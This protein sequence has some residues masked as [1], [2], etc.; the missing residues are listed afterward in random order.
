[1]YGIEILG[2]QLH[3]MR[4]VR[5]PS[6]ICHLPA[7]RAAI[8]GGATYTARFEALSTTSTF[9]GPFRHDEI[10]DENYASLNTDV[11]VR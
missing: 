2:K 5:L 7:R 3:G 8:D 11:V 6:H 1:V 10:I 9:S 4:A